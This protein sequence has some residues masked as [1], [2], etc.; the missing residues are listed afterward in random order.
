VSERTPG[1]KGSTL[2]LDAGEAQQFADFAEMFNAAGPHNDRQRI[3]VAGYWLQVRQG[4]QNLHADGINDLLT[5]IGHRIARVR[6]SLPGLMAGRPALVIRVAK[7]RS[8][9][10]RVLF[11][12]T[13][14]GIAAVDAALAGGGFETE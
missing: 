3:I 9:Q 13:T 4:E 11:R 7:G 10:A 8:K 1:P 14:A 5:P 2:T 6:D 12:L